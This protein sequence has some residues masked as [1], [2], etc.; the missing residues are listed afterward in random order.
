M[1]ANLGGYEK[2]AAWP[3]LI[4]PPGVEVSVHRF[5]D[6]NFP[7]RPLAMTSR[8]QCAIPKWFGFDYAPTADAIIWI[9]ASCVPEPS[10][11][12]WF[13][14]HLGHAEIA[15]F[16]HPERRTIREE[17]E[18]ITARM[19]RRGETYLR[20]RYA[21]EWLDGQFAVIEADGYAGSQ[22]FASTAFIYTPTPRVRA[23]LKEVWFG[24]TRWHLHDQLWLAYAVA[25]SRVVP[26]PINLNYLACPVLTYVRNKRRGAA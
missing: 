24:K 21:A 16:A 14:D 19:A 12:S 3:D 2:V 4:A 6:A 9:D 18:F 5:T 20:S 1:S 10:V 26:N 23:L 15:L 13:L 7:P 22:L 25:R 11:V 17:Y 8:L